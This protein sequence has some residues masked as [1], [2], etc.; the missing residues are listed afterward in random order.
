MS[1]PTSERPPQAKRRRT[2]LRADER[3]AQILETAKAVFA[4]RGYHGANVAHI[5]SAARIG[6]GTLY[7]Y[8]HNKRAVMLALLEGVEDRIRKVLSSR[9]PLDEAR[10]VRDGAEA[11]AALQFCERRLR[12]L[13]EAIFVD[14]PTLRLVAREARALDGV[15]GKSIDNIDTLVLTALEHD[16]MIAQRA[17]I[18]R[19]GDPT[20]YARYIL[21]GV[22]KII[23]M[24]LLKDE[25][26]KLD[27]I[28]H[29]AVQLELFGLFN[30]ERQP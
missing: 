22:E 9:P 30:L 23:L 6:R 28:V 25:P 17:R 13:L 15:L 21:G 14:E 2:Y 26:I 16:L 4:R 12:E 19:L 18:F 24:A 8:F 20:L 10:L 3:R 27:A 11:P 1:V 29:I 7:Q 5:C